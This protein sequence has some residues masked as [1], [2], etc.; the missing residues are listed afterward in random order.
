MRDSAHD[1][2]RR[3][4][5]RR[6]RRLAGGLLLLMLALWV[7]CRWLLTRY[8]FAWVGY[9]EAFAEAA[10][11][12]A[13][14]DWFAVTALFRHPFGLPIPHT[15]IIARN[16]DR[17]G[18]SVGRFIATEFLTEETVC[19]KLRSMD[20]AGHLGDWLSVPDNARLIAERAAVAVPAV[21]DAM[22]DDNVR[23]FVRDGV[24][25][26][27]RA[28]DVA[29][30]VGR[31]LGVLVANRRHQALFDRVVDLAG[32]F[33]RANH[34]VIRQRVADQSKWWMPK[35]VDEK[36]FQKI[37]NGIEDTLFELRDPGHPWRDQFAAAVEDYVRRLSSGQTH[38][39]RTAAIKEEILG[40][41]VFARYL[42]SVWGDVKL[43][44]REDADHPDGSLRGGIER[45]LLA[46]GARLR[47]DPAMRATVNAWVE[48]FAIGQLV[49]HRDKIGAFF[50]GV[51]HRWDIGTLV[52]KT[53]LLV[54]KDLQYI[55]IN[56]TLVG[57][58]VGVLIHAVAM[59]VERL[60]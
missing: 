11:V 24:V 49:P 3:D 36:L 9:V 41:P 54:G 48:R 57:G 39:E 52:S 44:L 26:S 45:A 18:G 31:M 27:L 37:V 35:F 29:P 53:E 47:A 4:E 21:L 55:R 19:H 40:N 51:V 30:M 13:I 1:L 15:A 58:T 6:M 8:G 38:H 17:L 23:G 34:E 43:R 7:A 20:V 14:A 32:D 42:E 50:A 59:A 33:L 16:K 46:V 25:R 5:L 60:G 22:G 2:I 10:M 28:L 12:G 56:G